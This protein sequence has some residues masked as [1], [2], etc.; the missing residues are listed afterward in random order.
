MPY[1]SDTLVANDDHFIRPFTSLNG[2]FILLV[3]SDG[4][5]CIYK[6]SQLK[7]AEWQSHTAGKGGYRLLMQTDGNLVLYKADIKEQSPANAV[8][9]TGTYKGGPGNR[10]VGAKAVLTNEGNLVVLDGSGKTIWSS[11][12]NQ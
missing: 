4:N 2:R 9:S 8:W 12:D 6:D 3:Q 7:V 10:G 5:M 11:K 1:S